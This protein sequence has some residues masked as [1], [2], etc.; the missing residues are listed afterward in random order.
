MS[1]IVRLHDFKYYTARIKL[2]SL[3]SEFCD[4]VTCVYI[5]TNLLGK[6]TQSVKRQFALLASI[7]VLQTKLTLLQTPMIIYS[8]WILFII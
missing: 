2:I 6:E 1:P 8:T 7:D 4:S 3:P 5:V